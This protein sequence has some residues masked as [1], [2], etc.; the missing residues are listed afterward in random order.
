MSD[1]YD[2]TAEAL[3]TCDEC[4]W[5]SLDEDDFVLINVEAPSYSMRDPYPGYPG[6]YVCA[7]NC[8]DHPPTSVTPPV[9]SLMCAS[10]FLADLPSGTVVP[11]I[12]EV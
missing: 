7:T 5:Q 9:G 8:D 4:G 10:T 6:D 11:G 12:C 1:R 2:D 3:F